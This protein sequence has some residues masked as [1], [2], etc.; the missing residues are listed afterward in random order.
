MTMRE[1]AVL[2]GVSQATVSLALRNH[3]RISVE[4]RVRVAALVKKHHYV[5]DGR[6]AELMRTIRSHSP[7]QLTGC[8]GLISFYP[9]ERPWQNVKRRPHLARM[10]RSM[11]ERADELGY[12]IEPFWIKN[13]AMNLKRLAQILEARG[14]K[15]LLSLG[16]PELEEEIPPELQPFVIVTQGT[17]IGTRLHRILGHWVHDT[18]LLLTTLKARG[19]RRPGLILQQHQ[20]GRNAHIIAAMYLYFSRYDFDRLDIPLLYAGSF[21]DQDAM[22]EWFNKHRPDVILYY[23]HENHYR[24]IETFLRNRKLAV[25]RDI[26]LAVLDATVHIAGVSGVHQNIEQMGVSAVEMLVSRLQQGEAG[27]P[28]VAKVESV[29]GKWIEGETLRLK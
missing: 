27:L 17:S 6:V 3:P 12:R 15:G 10:E 1:L 26:G 19:Y 20:D 22:G 13:P 28:K 2:A 25:P 14:I 5:V 23:D 21:V 9:E 16:A 29:E 8:L 7:E 18:T 24:S 11:V 4:T